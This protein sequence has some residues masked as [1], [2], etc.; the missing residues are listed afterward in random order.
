MFDMIDFG[1]E[2]TFT[3][4]L[5]INGLHLRPGYF[6]IPNHRKYTLVDGRTLFIDVNIPESA[7]SGICAIVQA[8]TVPVELLTD[9]E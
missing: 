1:I 3:A 9:Q 7:D 5:F 6:P 8:Q 2:H 4:R